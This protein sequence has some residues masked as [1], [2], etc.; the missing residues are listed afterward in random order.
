MDIDKG[1]AAHFKGPKVAKD[2]DSN[3]ET[4]D[5]IETGLGEAWGRSFRRNLIE[6]GPD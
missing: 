6:D 3:T 5:V 2:L 1:D 4:L